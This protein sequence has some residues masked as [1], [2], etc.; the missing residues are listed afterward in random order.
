MSL[1][2]W[3][4]GELPAQGLPNSRCWG[5]VGWVDRSMHTDGWM[6]GC[7]EVEWMGAATYQM[8]KA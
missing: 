4:Q 1:C 7:M 8:A 3:K 5:Q 6:D 2:C